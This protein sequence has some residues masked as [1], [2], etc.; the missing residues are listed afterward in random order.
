MLTDFYWDEAN[1]FFFLKK[2]IKM[3]DS[4]KLSFSTPP[5]INIFLRK[6][7]GLVLELVE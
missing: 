2:K 7:Q 6:F 3:A 5:I 4:K 1:F